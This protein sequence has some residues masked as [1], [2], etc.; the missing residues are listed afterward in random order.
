[1]IPSPKN[2]AAPKIPS[3]HQDRS[4]GHSVALQQRGQGH[5]PAVSAVVGPHD[6]PGVLDRDDDHQSPEDQGGGPE[7][8]YCADHA[9]GVVVGEDRLLGVEGAG[10]DVAV[11]DPEGAEGQDRL[12]GVGDDVAVDV[13]EG[14]EPPARRLRLLLVGALRRRPVAELVR[15]LVERPL[16]RAVADTDAVAGPDGNLTLGRLVGR[17][18]VGAL[19]R[20]VAHAPGPCPRRARAPCRLR[21]SGWAGPNFAPQRSRLHGICLHGIFM[22]GIGF[23]MRPSCPASQDAGMDVV[24]IVLGLLMFA[25]LF[26]LIYGID[27]I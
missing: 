3:D 22:A 23:C 9:R 10:A 21:A 15:G 4:V 13:L 12:A 1:M 17:L 19:M 24:S 6:E 2:N 8:V 7:H 20:R 18:V 27:A 5:D 26:A 25:I 11:D 16:L 14:L